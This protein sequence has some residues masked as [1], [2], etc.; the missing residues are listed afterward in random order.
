MAKYSGDFVL[1]SGHRVEVL[2]H[3]SGLE[4]YK[5]DGEVVLKSRAWEYSGYRDF[6]A[7]EHKV[8]IR[9]SILKLFCKA[10]VDG[11]LAVRDVFPKMKAQRDQ[12]R[13]RRRKGAT[14]AWVTFLFWVFVAYI[15]LHLFG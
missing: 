4:E 8:R 9:F 3:A 6:A 2:F 5:V 15:A 10:Y 14:P 7:G 12:W 13:G 1:P 11:K